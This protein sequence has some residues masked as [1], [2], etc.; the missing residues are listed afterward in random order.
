MDENYSP[1]AK[2]TKVELKDLIKGYK[3]QNKSVDAILADIKQMSQMFDQ[4]SNRFIENEKGIREYIKFAMSDRKK[5]DAENADA[6]KKLADSMAAFKKTLSSEMRIQVNKLSAISQGLGEL[7]FEEQAKQQKALYTQIMDAINKDVVAGGGEAIKP[8]DAIPMIEKMLDQNVEAFNRAAE[9]KGNGFFSGVTKTIGTF[10][11]TR[12][13]SVLWDGINVMTDGHAKLLVSNI[14]MFKNL[15][16]M[17]MGGIKKTVD[18]FREV[19]GK[20]YDKFFSQDLDSIVE[21]IKDITSDIKSVGN[22]FTGN[23]E[24]SKDDMQIDEQKQTNSLLNDMLDIEMERLG[25]DK[26]NFLKAKRA[27]DPK[28]GPGFW[29]VLIDILTAGAFLIGGFI[30]N[31]LRKIWETIKIITWPIKV[32][33]KSLLKSVGIFDTLVIWTTKA[34][35]LGITLWNGTKNVYGIVIGLFQSFSTWVGGLFAGLKEGGIIARFGGRIGGVFSTIRRVFGV[36]FKIFKP[37][38]GLISGVAKGFGKLFWPFQAI[39]SIVDF[40]SGFMNSDK[41]TFIGK[42]ADGLKAVV[43]GFL[44]LPVKFVGWIWEKFLTLLGFNAEG[45]T[46]KIFGIFKNIVSVFFDALTGNIQPAIDFF[47]DILGGIKNLA[48]KGFESVKDI[49]A[50]IMDVWDSIKSWVSGKIKSWFGGGDD[51]D[52]ERQ[53]K[54]D[55]IKKRGTKISEN[56]A[57]IAELEK[58]G[59]NQKDFLSWSTNGEKADKVRAENKKLEAENAKDASGIEPDNK[60]TSESSQLLPPTP[61]SVISS[62]EGSA[63]I[64]AGEKSSL[65][66]VSPGAPGSKATSKSS[67]KEAVSAANKAAGGGSLLGD[68]KRHEG[69]D[70]EVY[71]DSRGFWTGGYGTL[72]SKDSTLSKEQA[73]GL[74]SKMGYDPKASKED[75]NKYW[76]GKLNTEMTKSQDFVN[77]KIAKEGINVNDEQKSILA[78]MTYNL[79]EKGVGD[80]KKMWGALKEGDTDKAAAEMK[81][82]PWYG[83]VGDRS[84]ELVKRMRASGSGGAGSNMAS[85]ENELMNTKAGIVKNQNDVQADQSKTLEK[86]LASS[87]ANGKSISVKSSGGGGG[88]KPIE[89]PENVEAMSLMFLNTSWGLG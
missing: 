79:G 20:Y 23:K 29:T 31:A 68:L 26:D 4:T 67:V 32:I 5:S 10:L 60:L 66:G 25:I 78:N 89:P 71:K 57:K 7:D 18:F 39:L 6:T 69:Y 77:K 44:E 28:K 84:K 52:A 88:R 35:N 43:V 3:G 14:N 86:T 17:S 59:R 8:E 48:I 1:D 80:F 12:V 70:S 38:T 16:D 82:S 63:A 47:T 85:A 24:K 75:K 65:G 30:G 72:I 37:F 74:A 64:S 19:G 53:K 42:V 58:G 36:V 73:E 9:R 40:I 56:N 61:G 46:D 2:S 33:G 21:P 22:L 50:S 62:G 13:A 51:K 83:Q 55:A 15:F 76:T 54:L 11:D 45:L 81:D 49:F 34:K 87:T 41:D 27:R